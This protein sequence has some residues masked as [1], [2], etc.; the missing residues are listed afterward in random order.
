MGGLDAD[1]HRGRG[2]FLGRGRRE[3]VVFGGAGESSSMSPPMEEDTVPGG[4][5]SNLIPNPMRREERERAA[6]APL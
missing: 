6:A 4:R 2:G 3:A 1:V 5:V